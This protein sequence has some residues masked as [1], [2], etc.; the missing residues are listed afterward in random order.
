MKARIYM[1]DAREGGTYRMA[2]EYS[3][4]RHDVRGKSKRHAEAVW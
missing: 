2:F 3:D 1:F 4:A